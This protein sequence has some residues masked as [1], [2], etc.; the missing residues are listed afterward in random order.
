VANHAHL[1]LTPQTAE[2]VP[3]LLVSIGRRY[4]QYIDRTY[5]RTGTPRDGCYKSSLIQAESYPLNCQR[6]IAQN[7]VQAGMVERRFASS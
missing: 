3:K 6:Y 4:A 1:L 2:A 5:E 7:A